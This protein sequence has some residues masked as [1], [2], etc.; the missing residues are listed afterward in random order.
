MSDKRPEIRRGSGSRAGSS[1]SRSSTVSDKDSSKSKT[2]QGGSQD[3]VKNKVV[4]VIDVDTTA[5]SGKNAARKS[6]KPVKFLTPLKKTERAAKLE[7]SEKLTPKKERASSTSPTK[8]DS[9]SDSPNSKVVQQVKSEFHK[10]V[11]NIESKRSEDNVVAWRAN[12]QNMK[13]KRS[14]TPLKLLSDFKPMLFN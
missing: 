1:T 9:T 2:R 14:A 13:S 11:K 5:T 10:I 3:K 4:V 8:K 6:V 12:L 7:A